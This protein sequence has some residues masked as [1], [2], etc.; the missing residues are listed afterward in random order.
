MNAPAKD[1]QALMA[2]IAPILGRAP[3]EHDAAFVAAAASLSI[4]RELA[5]LNQTLRR[6]LG[7]IFEAVAPIAERLHGLT[8]AAE[9]ISDAIAR[10]GESLES[11]NF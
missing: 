1:L 6:E 7:E 3:T 4:A 10:A 5:E 11:P 2:A 9:N 8:A